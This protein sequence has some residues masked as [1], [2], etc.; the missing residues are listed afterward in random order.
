MTQTDSSGPDFTALA[1]QPLVDDDEVRRVEICMMKYTVPEVEVECAAAILRNTDWPFRYVAYDNRLNPANTAKMWNK[2]VRETTCPYV[3][4]LDSDAYAPRLTPCWLTC[5]MQAFDAGADVVLAAAN[6]CGNRQQKR[7]VAAKDGV[8]ETV[9]SP[10][11]SFV[12][13]FR[14]NLPE[15]FGPFDEE[16]YA[17]GPDTEFATRLK[18]WGGKALLCPDVL[19]YHVHAATH[20][21]RSDRQAERPF[22]RDLYRAKK[23]AMITAIDE[24]VT[25]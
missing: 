22:A 8:I 20:G 7:T 3:C 11:S 12:F 4:I 23:A 19:F 15:H 9:T 1:H 18:L 13:L 16:F 2:F 10:W 5:M 25:H 14:K 24:R 6:N 21:K 17:Y